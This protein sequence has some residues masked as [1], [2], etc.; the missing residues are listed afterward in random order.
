MYAVADPEK[1]RKLDEALEPAMKVSTHGIE[2]KMVP[3]GL[4]LWTGGYASPA[5]HYRILIGTKLYSCL[6]STKLRHTQTA[7]QWCSAFFAPGSA[8]LARRTPLV[9]APAVL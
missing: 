4:V 7:R 1:K 5:E 8:P 2:V 9:L 6:M 3:E